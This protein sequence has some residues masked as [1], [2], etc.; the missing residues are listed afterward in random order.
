MRWFQPDTA[1]KQINPLLRVELAATLAILCKVKTGKLNWP[2][3]FDPERAAFSL[4]ILIVLVGD[5]HLS[6][7]A[8]HEHPVVLTD[9][10]FWN[11]DV[12]MTEIDE[13]S[14]VLVVVREIAYLHL[15]D[16]SL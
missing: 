1:D 12:F 16:Q 3:V 5:I 7:D 13:F 10:A 14:P 9:I 11:M 15:I 2:H 6:P 4:S 8:T